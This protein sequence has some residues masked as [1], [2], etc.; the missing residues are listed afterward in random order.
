MLLTFEL[1]SLNEPLDVVVHVGPPELFLNQCSC[2]IETLVPNR[3]VALL[4]NVDPS[5]LLHDQLV[6]TTSIL[7]PKFSISPK[8]P[9]T[10]VA[11]P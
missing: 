6:F 3:V 10:V 5:I 11:F 2:S 4:Q 7:S 1:A 8:E 9:H